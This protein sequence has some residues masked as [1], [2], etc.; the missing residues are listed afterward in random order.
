MEKLCYFV[1]KRASAYAPK[2]KPRI[3]QEKTYF[4]LDIFLIFWQCLQK[5]MNTPMP[6]A[7]VCWAI[8]CLQSYLMR[9]KRAEN[10][11]FF[12]RNIK[13]KKNHATK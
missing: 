8:N 10:T 7:I 11:K 3:L 9:N 12:I 5:I 4:R 13:I 6:S 1:I 2:C